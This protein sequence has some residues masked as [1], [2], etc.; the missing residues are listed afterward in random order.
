MK[1]YFLI[2]FCAISLP[3]VSQEKS[4]VGASL[5]ASYYMGDINPT[6]IFYSPQFSAGAVYRYNLNPRY[7]LKGELTYVE[8]SGRDADFSDP[9]QQA[10]N[11]SFSAELYDI[12]AQFEFN[13]LPLKFDERKLSFSPFIST[14]LAAAII[15]SSNDKKTFNF[16]Y[17][18]ALGFRMTIGK[19]WSTGIQWSFRKTFND[20]NIDGIA[21]PIPSLQKS[22]F[23]NNDWYSFAGLFL[24]YKIFDFGIPCPAYENKF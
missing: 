18:I 17:P 21:N 8:L 16:V 15:L 3:I 19:K 5:G 11:A 4:D 10:R 9:Y 14:G 22:S 23:I 13:F 12:A 6:K 20:T 7:V 2:I 24:T 1:N